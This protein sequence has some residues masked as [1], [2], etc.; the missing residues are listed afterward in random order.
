M[1]FKVCIEV[2]EVNLGDCMLT[3]IQVHFLEEIVLH[4]VSNKY[5]ILHTTAV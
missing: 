3:L 5:P 1:F 2:L 4:E